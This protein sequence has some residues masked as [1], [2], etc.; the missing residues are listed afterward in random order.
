M[1]TLSSKC[2][3]AVQALFEMGLVYPNKSLSIKEIA[4]AQKIPEDYLRQL[5]LGLKKSELVKSTRG[6][7][8]GYVLAKSPDQIP[9]LA[10]VESV[11][12]EINLVDIPLN[13]RVLHNFWEQRSAELK[14]IFNATLEDLISEKK[15]QDAIQDYHI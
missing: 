11:E 1:L 2:H 13:D 6:V 7:N 14:K 9:M 4:R 10:I 8:G 5:L 3:Y 15:R 12:G